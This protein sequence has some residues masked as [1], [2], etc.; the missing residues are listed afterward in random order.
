MCMAMTNRARIALELAG[1]TTVD[2]MSNVCALLHDGSLM[3]VITITF[4]DDMH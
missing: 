2:C 3:H 1:N 4:G